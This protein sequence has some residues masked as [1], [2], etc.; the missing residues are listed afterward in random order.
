M[1]NLFK[2]DESIRPYGGYKLTFYPDEFVLPGGKDQKL[3]HIHVIGQ[4]GE[5]RVYLR[6]IKEKNDLYIETKR[7]N[8]PQHKQSKIKDFINNYY[9]LIIARVEKELKKVGMELK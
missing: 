4:E 6:K 7:G 9:D 3:L 2:K 5:I 1:V 8:I